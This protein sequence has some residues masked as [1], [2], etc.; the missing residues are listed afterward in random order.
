MPESLRFDGRVVIVTGAGAGLGKAYA[1]LFASRGAGVVVNDLGGSRHGDGSSTKSADSVVAEIR[2]AGGK[3][4]AN[5][6]SVLDGEKI[7]KTA[8]DTFGRIDVVVN[9]AGILRDKSFQKMTEKDWD[10]IHDV[11]L[12]GAVKTTQAAWPYFLKQ[13]YGRVIVTASN[14]GLYG[15]FGQ[16]NYSS[17]KMG[18]VGLAN[19]LS[20]EGGKKNIYT[21]VIVPT[22]GSRLTEDIVPPDFFNELKPELIAPVVFWLCHEDCKENGSIIESALGWAGKCHIVRASGANLRQ[23]IKQGVT[24]EDVQNNWG[25]VTDMSSA[26]HLDNIQHATGELFNVLEQMKEGQLS[27]SGEISMKITYNN[28]DTILYALG[29][30]ATVQEPSDLQYL[31]ENH[32]NFSVLPTFYVLYG[33]MACMQTSIMQDSL[34]GLQIDPTRILHGEQFL[35][36][37]KPLPTEGVI[38]VR[39][40]I[41]DILD[42]GKGAVLLINHDTYNAVSGE[43]LSTGQM[44]AFLVGTSV[45]GPRNSTKVIPTIEAPK[46]KPDVSISQKTSL[47]QA[48]LYRLSGDYNPLHIDPNIANMAGFQKPIL[49]GLCS[50]GFSVRHVIQG[51]GG[52]DPSVFKSVKARFTK[53]VLP[54]QV[55]RTDMWRNGN[56]IHFE[57]VVADT[58]TTVVSGAYV[59]LKEVK[60]NNI[61]VNLTSANEDMQS[62]AIFKSIAEQVSVQPDVA[63]KVNAVF[64]YNITVDG[65]HKSKWTLDLKKAEVY[66]GEPKSGKA[67]ATLTIEDKD[68]V[69]IALGKL[70]PQMAFMKGKLKITGNIMIT[71]KL[72][73]LMET[74]KPKL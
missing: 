30:G 31:Y 49:H 70:N 36:I 27:N 61:Q 29:V 14:S 58:N 25:K 32:D 15:N 72:K 23:C 50:L 52:G 22:A 41:Q 67:D 5:Y 33:P 7:I 68:M 54:G 26:K 69:Q 10:L 6:D 73:N 51:F 47:D 55:L 46:R 48:A 2:Q 56:R 28:R 40:S 62:D 17:A 37:F 24:P 42:K 44:S 4:V 34:P 64:L 66:K 18:L 71:Q 11:H 9:N 53:P 3:A 21:N 35:E 43:K 74:S 57:T 16:A 13:K 19:T 60:M 1:L 63:K 65:Q 39:A 20:I 12:K 45:K 38:E 8:I 59:D